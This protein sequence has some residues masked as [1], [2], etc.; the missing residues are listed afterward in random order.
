MKRFIFVVV[1]LGV[2]GVLRAEAKRISGTPV[3]VVEGK[4]P[5]IS[6]VLMDPTSG[7]EVYRLRLTLPHDGDSKIQSDIILQM[8][9][10]LSEAQG[11]IGKLEKRI[12][13]LEK[14]K[15]RP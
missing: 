3:P 13:A 7:R 9:R 15:V 4:T 5:E 11:R 8:S 14:K 12:D 1:A 6:G 10:E 2:S